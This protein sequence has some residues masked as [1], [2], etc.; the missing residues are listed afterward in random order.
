VDISTLR[1][2]DIFTLRLHVDRR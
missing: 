2:P 1:K